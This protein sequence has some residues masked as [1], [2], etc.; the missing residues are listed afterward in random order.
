MLIRATGRYWLNSMTS[1]PEIFPEDQK[2]CLRMI[3]VFICWDVH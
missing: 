2:K 3:S 1:L